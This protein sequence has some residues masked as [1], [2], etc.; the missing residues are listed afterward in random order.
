MV[1]A[2]PA[3]QLKVAVGNDVFVTGRPSS[4][5]SCTCQNPRVL[6]ECQYEVTGPSN[7][8]PP[9]Y[10]S[11]IGTIRF[12]ADSVGRYVDSVAY[13]FLRYNSGSCDERFY[14]C[15]GCENHYENQSFLVNTYLDN[16]IKIYSHY[17]N[18]LIYGKVVDSGVVFVYD[19]AKNKYFGAVSKLEIY[20]NKDVNVVFDSWRLAL[21]SSS[22]ITFKCEQDSIGVSSVEVT[23]GTVAQNLLL[24]FTTSLI[25]VRPWRSFAG[26]VQCMAH[27]G[28]KDSLCSIPLIF[29]FQEMPRSGLSAGVDKANDLEIFPNPS[30]GSGHALCTL[31]EATQ[32]HLHIFDEL[33]KDV[34]VVYDGGLPAG[35][36]LFSFKLPSGVYYV[37]METKDGVLTEK[38]VVE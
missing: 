37:R 28:G 16:A 38:L 27:F 9:F 19:T 3:Q 8:N 32:L 12:K 11:D 4:V 1:S 26:E 34:F 18:T 33:G 25:P 35:Q 6:G 15:W 22:S 21:D 5:E 13:W 10:V 2:S 23:A 17:Y 14:T 7:V 29:M 30:I 31:K 36:H 24:D 20:N